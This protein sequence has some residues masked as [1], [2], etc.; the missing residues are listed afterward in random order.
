MNYNL[1]S[2]SIIAVLFIVIFASGYR[3]KQTEK[4]YNT[5]TFNVHKL[6]GLAVIAALIVKSYNI[7]QIS[8][9]NLIQWFSIIVNGILF[10]TVV[11]SGGLLSIEKTM[12]EGLKMWHLIIS[13]LTL[14]STIITIYVTSV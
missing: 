13:Y 8:E 1:I 3:L 4:P 2:I 5:I 7:Y 10:L 12:P 6:I 11:I 9:Y 14:I